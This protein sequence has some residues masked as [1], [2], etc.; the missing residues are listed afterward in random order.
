MAQFD[1]LPLHLFR[2][3]RPTISPPSPEKEQDS[4]LLKAIKSALRGTGVAPP[5]TVH[6]SCFYVGGKDGTE[7]E[8]TWNDSKVILTVGGVVKK[9]WSFELEGQPVQ[10]A[11][12]GWMEESASYPRK[13]FLERQDPASTE[14]PTFGPFFYANQNPGKPSGKREAKI[15][16]V[17]VFLRSIGKIYLDSGFEHTFSLPF[18]VRRA[19]PVTP[20]G[21]LI[22]RVLE[23]AELVEAQ[24]SDE[25]V[26]PTIFCLSNPFAEP[27][28]VGLTSGIIGHAGSATLK[29]EDENSTKP[30]KPISPHEIILWTSYHAPNSPHEIVVTLDGIKQRLTVWRY[31]YI[32]PKDSPVPLGRKETKTPVQKK[33]QS[34]PAHGRRTSTV[35]PDMF[36]KIHPVSPRPPSPT[37][38]AFPDFPPLSKLPGMAPSLST[39]TTMAS[40]ASGTTFNSSKPTIQSQSE[41]SK[42]RRNSLTRND[43]SVTMNR[44][45]LGSRGND[46][47]ALAPIE[48]GRM[49]TTLWMDKLFEIDLDQAE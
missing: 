23:P 43:L 19:W 46:I 10:W 35:F 11:C 6:S 41:M 9:K 18:I 36:D 21:L 5:S 27:S 3:N 1:P 8:L 48:H 34:M 17:F 2:R 13:H 12:I 20:H 32:K 26:L 7:R 45:A 44:M 33:R 28:A 24:I 49:K 14:R 37:Q 25:D 42:T 30:L 29:D 38:Q 39:M 22:Q 16:A 47:D 40:L 4:L 15:A 31:V